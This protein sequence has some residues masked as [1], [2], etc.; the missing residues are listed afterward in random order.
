MEFTGERFIPTEQ[1]EIRLEHY[2]RYAVVLDIVSGKDVLDV[3]CGEGYGSFLMAEVARTVTGVDISKEAIRHAGNTYKNKSKL[4]F[5][6]DSVTDL[7]LADASFDVVVS[8]ETIEHLTEQPQMLAEIRRVLRPDGVLILSSPNRP[9]YSE[10]DRNKNEFH[11]K[12][13]DFYELD[14]LVRA[15][16]PAVKYLGQ[17]LMIGSVVQPLEKTE[18]SFRA[19]HDDGSELKPASGHLTDPVYFL[20]VCAAQE[21]MLPTLK[22][23]I[24]HP[25]QLDLLK[26][27]IGY[28]QWAKQSNKELNQLRLLHAQLDQEHHTVADWARSLD[29]KLNLLRKLIA[30]KDA[31]YQELEA[32]N[33]RRGEWGVALQT[34]LEALRKLMAE[35]DAAYQELAADN[36]RRGEWALG[37]D[38]QLKEAQARIAQITS[39]NSW[40]ITL[41]LREIREWLTNPFSQ[42]KRYLRGAAKLAR[43]IYMRLPLSQQTKT[44]HRLFLIKHVP[45]VLRANNGQ[46][47]YVSAL[48]MSTVAARPIED[49]DVEAS[50]IKL[51]TSLQPV[52]SVI[53][54]IYGKC[55]YT[56]RCLASIAENP[57]STPFEIIVVDDCSPDNSA[58]VLQRVNGIRLISNLENQGFIRSCNIGAKAANGQ[59]LYFLN[60]DTEVI[61]GWLDE[62]VRTFHEFPGT[63]L[64]GSKLV[65][66][67]GTLQEAGGIIWQDGSAWNFGRNQDPS[68]P[69][70]NYARD[71]DYC[72]G[73]SIMVPKGLF[74]E[75]GAFDEHYLPAYCED[76]DL[77]LKIR[78]RGQRVIYQPLSV[79]V[80]Y[81][82]VTSGTDLTQ[83][84]KAYQVE[85]SKKLFARWQKLLKHHQSPGTEVDSAKDRMTKRRVLVIDHCTPTPNKDAG[86]VTV[87][88]LLL[89]L[90]EMGFQVTFIPEDNF[91]YMPDYTPALQ[92]AGIEVLYAPHV[93]SVD[94]HLKE[95]GGRYD[96]AFL[97]RPG[98]VERHLKAIRRHSPKARVLFH[99]VDLHYLRMSREADLL[100]DEAKQRA[101]NQMKQRELAAI[102]AVDASIVHSTTEIEMLRQELPEERI[103]VFPLILDIR[104]TDKGFRD[105]RD[106]VF[107]GGY[108]HT[109]NVDAVQYFVRDVMPILRRRLPGVCFYVAG[110]KVPAG[111]QALA[112]EDVIITG[113]VEE[114]PLLLD[115]MRVAVAPLRYGAGIKGKIGTT[116]AVG[117]PTIATSL[118][119]EGMS[120][121][122]GENILVNDGAEAFA[123]A[124]AQLYGDETLWKK[125]S[126][127]GLEFAEKTWGG[128]AA[129]A[130]LHHILE[131]IG[132]SSTRGGYPLR[133]YS[134][135]SKEKSI[136]MDIQYHKQKTSQ[137]LQSV[138]V[139]R[140]KAEFEQL[141]LTD[142]IKQI[143]A[144]ESELIEKSKGRTSFT[145]E[146]FCVPCNQTVSFLVDMLSGGQRSGQRK[147]DHWIPNWRE[148]LE[149]PLC[150]MINRQRLI[151]TLVS[152]HLKMLNSSGAKVY[153]MEQVT[154]IYNWAKKAFPDCQIVGSEYLGHEYP[155]GA[156]VK[157]IRHEDI[158]AL[159]FEDSSID[160][161]VSN[162]VFEHVPNPDRAFSE[163]VRVL[164]PGGVMLATIPFHS[165]TDASVTRATLN[166]N[167]LTHLMP[168]MYH[169]NPVSADGSLV[170]TDFGWDILSL[171]RS[172]GFSD[173]WL[174]IYASKDFGHLGLG[175][176]VFRG[177][178]VGSEL[179]L[180]NRD[181]SVS[182]G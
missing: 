165:N 106:V 86:S 151:A 127:N 116:M 87:F 97:F 81:E 134:P 107:V 160:L 156:I 65:Y 78:D 96:L 125:L 30:D 163:C 80:H 124:V 56:L 111:I 15:H 10:A 27:Y 72:S 70:Y 175:Q 110:S 61:P 91:L 90:R 164:R 93:T 11:V 69:I 95:S 73:A 115:R 131:D 54:P 7:H 153:F 24:L 149:C 9:I 89:L 158:M 75:L 28:A 148:R 121:T 100:G 182:S 138:G 119:A 4:K 104:G 157:G 171:M 152:Q 1:G 63:G 71:V 59:Y 112:S 113:F 3:A 140:T 20:A 32:D 16:F 146:G 109:P 85:N 98:I 174:E 33:V 145:A 41:P 5:L 51:T 132:I 154:V 74:D 82:G 103:H 88:N 169:G 92:R 144:L 83:G 58:E 29:E 108:Q 105:R 77:A 60:N 173:V 177:E 120:L 67:D 48:P 40:K 161:I 123:E 47:I 137:K 52:V 180:Q 38:R 31:A 66:P 68:L 159:S 114:L 122:N 53:I 49:L 22:A 143:A 155:G 45:W 84:A 117:L 35:K 181:K 167:G 12:E 130:T 2:H 18:D 19:W 25:D 101:A 23:S 14:A 57:P 133:L 166:S 128:E 118:A 34:E 141:L 55:D 62:L 162:D 136:P 13:L 43:A 46:P 178:K 102:R 37:L 129:W 8:F 39:S 94:Q 142:P 17:R 76:A 168:P 44:D 79:V 139:C 126:K 6:Q 42:A 99:T 36:I 179:S 176:I 64:V 135:D 170:F 26:Q 147:D 150:H 50:G 172:E 21:S